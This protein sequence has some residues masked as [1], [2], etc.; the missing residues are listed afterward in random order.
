MASEQPE[1]CFVVMPFGT[2]PLNDGSGR[3]YDFDKVYR[4]IIQRAIRQAGLEPAR[5]DERKVSDIIH[6]DM[7]KQLR[8]RGVVLADLSLENPNV[9]YELG[10]RHVMS[11]KG[12]VLMCRAGSELPFDV[13]LSRVIFYDYDGST[14]TGRRS[15]ASSMSCSSP[16]RRPSGVRPTA[17]C[18]RCSSGCCPTRRLARGERHRPGAT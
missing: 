13:K 11:A 7:F 12:T 14:W 3:L 16:S 6:A 4:V 17:R 2:K 9:F 5:A 10:A 1:Q 15:S 8:D 18:T